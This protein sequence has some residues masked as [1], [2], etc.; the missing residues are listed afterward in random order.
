MRQSWKFEEQS[1]T[2]K[3]LAGKAIKSWMKSLKKIPLK[4][5]PFFFFKRG[6]FTNGISFQV[7]WCLKGS[8]GMIFLIEKTFTLGSR[9]FMFLSKKNK[10]VFFFY[11]S[12]KKSSFPWEL[13]S[14]YGSFH[15]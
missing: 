13:I 10:K 9:K 5:F 4:R 3:K 6:I 14:Q 11:E 7:L 2:I 8:A 12:R 15:L 1:S